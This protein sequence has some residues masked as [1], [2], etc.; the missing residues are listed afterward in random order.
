M[1]M[2]AS[3]GLECFWDWVLG[4][5]AVTQLRQ[6]GGPVPGRASLVRV[7]GLAV[8]VG[9]E[10]SWRSHVEVFQHTLSARWATMLAARCV[11]SCALVG[12]TVVLPGGVLPRSAW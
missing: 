12:T 3:M 9:V 10:R 2:E 8:D 4:C 5:A 6:M 7:A 1:A 11:A